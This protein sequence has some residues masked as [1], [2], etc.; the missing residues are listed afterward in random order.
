MNLPAMSMPSVDMDAVWMHS[1]PASRGDSLAA[2]A[3]IS[4][5]LV[6]SHG[7]NRT[8]AAAT[9]WTPGTFRSQ[10]G[11]NIHKL[12]EFGDT[13]NLSRQYMTVVTML[14]HLLIGSA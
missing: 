1:A 14:V 10:L 5:F 4:T 8:T 9:Q 11:S 12:C 7:I 2:T 13:K 3:M 6:N